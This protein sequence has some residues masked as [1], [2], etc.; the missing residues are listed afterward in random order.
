M[1]GRTY[2][3]GGVGAVRVLSAADPLH[4]CDEEVI[5]VI[6]LKAE[7]SALTVNVCCGGKS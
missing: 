4:V 2:W 5:F 3:E 1:G 7:V 6:V